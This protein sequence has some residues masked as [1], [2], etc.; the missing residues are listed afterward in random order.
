DFLVYRT[1]DHK[2]TL[3]DTNVDD[4]HG[5]MKRVKEINGAKVVE[6]GPEEENVDL[7]SANDLQN[8]DEEQ[9][10]LFKPYLLLQ[11]RKPSQTLNFKK[12]CE[13]HCNKYRC[14]RFVI[15]V[16]LL[17]FGIGTIVYCWTTLICD[18]MNPI[19]SCRE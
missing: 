10:Y 1:E 4:K 2:F 7:E 15:L 3:S 9:G 5:I 13:A 14:Y 19:L 6:N 8:G 12:R 18:D 17:I 16:G 11:S